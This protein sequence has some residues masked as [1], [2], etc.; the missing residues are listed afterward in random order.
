MFLKP[1]W[2]EMAE[3]LDDAHPPC[4]EDHGFGQVGEEIRRDLVGPSS[5][6]GWSPG[7][8]MA[9]AP[10][11][12]AEKGLNEGVVSQHS[13]L[14]GVM[15]AA[16]PTRGWSDD[17]TQGRGIEPRDQSLELLVNQL[18]QQNAALQQELAE[19]RLYSSSGSGSN[20]S[21]ERRAE[22]RGTQTL[23]AGQ[24]VPS[25]KGKGRGTGLEPSSVQATMD[26]LCNSGRS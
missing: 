21:G 17:D 19:A 14:N 23:V 26:L 6:Q 22:G 12:G 7:K 4:H 15:P 3:E 25:R 18:L 9:P 11:K 24:Y 2:P 10:G 8:R 13:G 16:S 20:A 5:S 1:D